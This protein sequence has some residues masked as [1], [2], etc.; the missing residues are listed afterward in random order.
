M[1]F[2]VLYLVFIS[3]LSWTRPMWGLA[4]AANAFLVNAAVGS[5]SSTTLYAL[6]GVGGPLACFAVLL[7]KRTLMKKSFYT[8]FG[9]EGWSVVGLFLCLLLSALYASRADLA[10]NVAFRYLV[11][12]ASFFFAVRFVL[13]AAHDRQVKI[14][15]F[16]VAIMC[17]GLLASIYAL[18]KGDS[19]SEYVVRLTIG[20]VSSIPLSILVGQSFLIALYFLIM[21]QSSRLK[22][23][24]LF[25]GIVILLYTEILTNTRSTV[26]GIFLGILV[27]LLLSYRK[28]GFNTYIKWELITLIVAL[29]AFFMMAPDDLYKRG[30]LGFER[31]ISGNYG[32]SEEIRLSAWATALDIF[33]ENVF[34]GIGAGNFSQHYFFYYPHNI[35]F[36]VLS[37]NGLVG[38]LFLL[39]LMGTAFKSVLR[40]QSSIGW[41]VCALFVFSFFVAQ[42]SLTLW[43][44]KS[45]FIW[46]SLLTVATWDERDSVKRNV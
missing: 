21:E 6:I 2:A 35:F 28:F 5:G 43:M 30:F 24:L 25:V 3:F 19:I 10:L 38:F 45:L 22:K 9:P 29:I 8:P 14:K 46:L 20:N 41:L 37:E 42:V 23:I 33:S 16:L 27:F 11:F 32:E 12:C 4:L 7:I 44:H 15:E 40:L 31:L 13:F 36:E 1:I 34:F 17:I 39:I 18:V 26:I